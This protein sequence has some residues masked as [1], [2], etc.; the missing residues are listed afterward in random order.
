MEGYANLLIEISNGIGWVR[1]NRPDVLNAVNQEVWL[2]VEKA[3]QSLRKDKTVQVLVLSGNDRAFV[4]GADV[5][6]MAEADSLFA[7]ELAELT[8]R[9]QK[10]IYE[11]P[12]PTIAAISGY[13]LGAG[14]EIALC[15][16][17]RIA[18]HDA[19]LGLPEINLGIIP[20][21]GGT[22]RL[23][24][25]TNLSIATRMV[26]TGSPL[27]A[28]E[29]QELGLLYKVVAPSELNTEVRKL[30]KML[31]QKPPLALM[32]AKLALHRGIN[33]SLEAG[34]QIEEDFFCACFET[35]DQKEGMAAFLEK[36][37]PKFKGR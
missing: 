25:L 19:V 30:A 22:Q 24:R 18:T 28:E 32:A 27:K 20:G 3:V 36:R 15:C 37:K 4:A 17:F 31:T 29:S 21:G 14:L 1:F 5:D 34:L 6:K 10:S 2:D 13:A 26:L 23:A 9:V 33:T 11:F 7:Y 8:M 16:D 12:L 35:E